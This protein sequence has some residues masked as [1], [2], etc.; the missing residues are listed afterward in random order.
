MIEKLKNISLKIF[1]SHIYLL[2]SLALLKIIFQII[3]FQN[4][5]NWLTADDYSRTVIS[6]DW[7][8]D[9]RIYSGVWLSL[10]FWLNGLFIAIF[11]DL[12]LSSVIA[13][14][15]F[16]ALTLC[17]FYF[18]VNKIFDRKTAVI[19]SLIYCV[20][21]FQAWLSS[22]GMPEPS[23][24]FFV[25]ASLFYFLKWY[26]FLKEKQ[27][28]KANIHLT[29]SA[30]LLSV[31]NLLRYEGWFFSLTL[32]LLTL[33]VLLKNRTVVKQ[34]VIFIF[35]S[36]ISLAS[37]FWWFYL[38]NRDYNDAFFFIKETTRIY[39]DVAGTGTIQRIIQYPFFIFY[40]APLT[41]ILAVWKIIQ[42]IRNKRN[43]FIGN[44]SLLKL[45]LLFNLVELTLLML[46]GIFGSGGTNMI[47]RYIVLNAMFIFPFAVWQ[48]FDFKKY[49]T[50]GIIGVA[51]SINVIW[52][53]Y[54]QLAYREDTYEVAQ[55]TKKLIQKEYLD[56]D[57]KIYFEPVDGYYDI[58]PMQVISNSPS[59]F[60]TDTIPST[61]PVTL[62]GKRIN[63][64]KA[65][66]E[67]Q[68]LNILSLRKFLEEKNVKLCIARNELLIDKLKKLSFKNEVIGDY[69]IFYI[70]D[71]T[72]K[73]KRD[74]NLRE[75]KQV[76]SFSSSEISFDKKLLLK[77]YR[78]DNSN[79]GMNPQTI[80]LRW[81]I[82]DYSL[83]DSLSTNDDPFG[84]YKI[85]IGLSEH[86]NDSTSFDTYAQVFSERNVEEFFDDEE[87][88]NIIVLK[89]FA[90]L[91]YTRQFKTAPFESG[92]Y[93]VKLSLIDSR[94]NK[95]M[96]VFRGDSLY[97][98]FSGSEDDA[99]EAILIGPHK[100]KL[101]L[102]ELKAK[103]LN[104]PYYPLGKI[105]AMF[106]NVDYK[107]VLRQ[108]KDLSQI[109]LRN[110]LM[111]P[112]L[113]RY[114]GDHMLD[115]LFKYF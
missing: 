103:F 4:G 1:S 11:K 96:D 83:L 28:T 101:S 57:D 81:E 10:H 42:T 27:N 25:T 80:T 35:I 92:L 100:Q 84:R 24:F 73:V 43:G 64:K 67:R 5:M 112:F 98:N 17:Y 59:K 19:S 75:S 106:P 9:P 65:E 55:L 109:I 23:F 21:P 14:S 41:T 111:L 18:I 70:S 22:S 86:Q 32:I 2:A 8:Q 62:P 49:L 110:G 48:V 13:N 26:E 71:K 38:N 34:A 77:D 58:Y 37:I 6:W 30:L 16:S 60:I 114:Q 102:Q 107:L 63:K 74:T 79:F 39:K 89:P 31:A 88:K 108:S 104:D 12:W 115:V 85:K 54:Y 76:S 87:I 66:E 91:Q 7:L 51:I 53:F 50:V 72:L 33:L 97:F 29:I 46:S 94:Y 52:C 99:A 45:F 78:I 82:V 36:L 68:R 47:S 113:N 90:L 61:F 3:L 20:F 40:I 56:N 44:F 95:K 93:D 15:F 69:H 105:I